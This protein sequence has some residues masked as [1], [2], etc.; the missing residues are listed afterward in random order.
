M[1]TTLKIIGELEREDRGEPV[2]REEL[3]KALELEALS[4]QITERVRHARG[5]V[6]EEL[7]GVTLAELAEPEPT[8]EEHVAALPHEEL[9]KGLE[10]RQQGEELPEPEVLALA[11]R[12]K[13][14]EIRKFIEEPSPTLAS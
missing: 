14:A 12:A 1:E 13:A 8:K 11:L 7:Q 5:A 3:A 6:T 2:E 4:L 10:R 9:I